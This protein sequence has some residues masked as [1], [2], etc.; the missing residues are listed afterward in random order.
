MPPTTPL[1]IVTLGS[2]LRANGFPVELIDVPMDFG[3]GITEAAE[4]EVV[5]RI[6]AYLDGGSKEIL[7][8]GISCLAQPHAYNSLLLAYEIKAACPQIPLI[9]G[10]YYPS[11]YHLDL[12]QH[13]HQVI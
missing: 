4:R 10:G 8:I 11:I 1:A 13:H 3:F 12:L 6:A 5:R 7:W 9:F 2:F